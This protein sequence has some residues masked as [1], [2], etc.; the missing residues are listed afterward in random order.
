MEEELFALLF[1]GFNPSSRLVMSAEGEGGEDGGG[2]GG[3]DKPQYLTKNDAQEMVNGALSK[4]T[5]RNAF[6]E[7]LTG[8]LKETL[9]G[10]IAEHIKQ[11]GSGDQG[12]GGDGG[13]G[14]GKGGDDDDPRIKQLMH[15]QRQM[16]AKL[17][18]ETAKRK[19]IADEALRKEE[20]SALRHELAK[21]GVADGLLTAAESLLFTEKGSIARDEDNAIGMKMKRDWGE[22]VV[23]LE[24]AI[25]EWAKSDEGKAFM[26]AKP[27]GGTGNIGGRLAGKGKG[28]PKSRQEKMAALGNLILGNE[29]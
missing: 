28:R 21:V 12:G 7:S 19:Q 17:E 29:G 18:E 23:P 4:F 26:P 10:I 14:G 13:D 1:G 22:E 6:K 24:K 27:I 2:D 16:Q 20:R 3:D 9:P 15:N 11:P 8:I 5:S 25:A